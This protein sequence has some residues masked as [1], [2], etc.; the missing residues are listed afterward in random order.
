[1]EGGMTASDT[2]RAEGTA[3]RDVDGLACDCGDDAVRRAE[4]DVREAAAEEKQA[5][6]TLERAEH[7]L[8]RAESELQEAESQQH[9]IEVIVDRHRKCVAVG[10]YIVS[11]FKEIVGVAPDRE[12]DIL[13]DGVLDPLDDST[14]ITIHCH[15]VFVSHARTGGSS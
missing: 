2:V 3:E 14:K 8:E 11:V 4:A 10:T 12:L 6:A 7:D 15:E 1:M 13:K 5:V 9:L